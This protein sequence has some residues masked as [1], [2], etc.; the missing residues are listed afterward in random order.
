[1]VKN[2]NIASH[3]VGPG[4]PCFIIAEAGVNHNGDIHIARQL[5]EAASDAGADAIKFQ[6][7]TADNLITV[8]L[9]LIHI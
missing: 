1:M 2:L 3:T 7:F 4:C 6:T 8:D 9:S 5:V